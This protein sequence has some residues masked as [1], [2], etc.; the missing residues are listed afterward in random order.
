MSLP[1]GASVKP[2]LPPDRALQEEEAGLRPL[3]GVKA[4]AGF[5]SGAQEV[6]SM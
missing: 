1:W 5:F 4:P 2:R 3:G 6:L